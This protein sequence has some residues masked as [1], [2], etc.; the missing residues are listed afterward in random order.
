MTAVPASPAP[1]VDPLLTVRDLRIESHIGGRRHSI[2]TGIDL[3]I[4]PGE[5]VGI[6]G[7]SGSGK[8]M[9][10]RALIGLLPDGVLAQG[11][12]RYGGRN[13][14]E[15]PERA[16]AQLRGR[17]IG[18]IMQDPFTMLSPLL[19]CGRHI[20]EALRDENGRKL[21]KAARRAEAVRRL[22]EVGIH[23]PS[24]AD[25]FP[26]ELSGGMRQRVGIAAALARDPRILI[27]DE[28]STALDVTTQ[29]EILALL[30]SLQQS[31]AMGLIL[32]THDL[33]VAF[34]MCD[35]ITVLYAGSV[36]EVA[37]AQA[38]EREPLHPY[39][40]GLLLSEPPG[41]RRLSSLVAI[42]GSVA[43]PDEVTGVCAFSPRCIW[44]APPCRAGKPPLR[45]LA[46]GRLSACIRIEEIQGPMLET[47]ATANRSEHV[48]L[49]SQG[50]E[51]LVSVQEL[52]KVFQSGRGDRAR[53]VNA[54]A[55]VSVELGAGESVGLVGESGSGKTTLARC[56]MGLE[57]PTS[58][59]IAIDGIDATSYEALSGRERARLRQSIQMIFQDP[60]STLN[61]V[62][63]VGATLKEAL[64]MGPRGADDLDGRLRTLLERVGLPEAYAARKPVALS[65]GERQ[66][67]A[68][69]RALAVE[70]KVIVC[71]E[72]ASALDVSV[73]AQILNLL[74]ALRDELGISYFFITH[75]LAVVRQLVERIYV[76]HRGQVVEAGPVD[77]V[78][79]QP[80]DPYTIRLIDSVPRSEGEWL[81][82]A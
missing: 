31:R 15:L 11:A 48:A 60:Y 37:R 1:A 29:K 67:I 39:T 16:L 30:R 58:G 8:S 49:P 59:R 61:P 43:D 70:P 20:D 21:G 51:A 57:T 17:E 55:G 25:R 2:V 36:L 50:R 22:A 78:L 7:E 28:P 26:F 6:V 64:A 82:Q 18:L 46:G 13:L 56:L 24:V 77:S 40:L 14:L 68:I 35:R 34:S 45:E 32:I 3:D 10:A 47:R 27:A 52:T 72:P 62:R 75:D 80:Q 12:V 66:R 33:R 76:L 42:P 19:R 63:T 69:A 44:A 81:S 79:D 71:D 53:S 4:A 73:Q 23:D 41:D 5:T 9:T 38:L 65:G 54:L 74:R